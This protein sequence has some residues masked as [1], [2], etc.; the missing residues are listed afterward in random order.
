MQYVYD[1]I[2]G[3]LVFIYDLLFTLIY[4]SFA[5]AAVSIIILSIVI[6]LI[7]LPLY[8][9]ADKL[10]RDTQEK[11]RS[12]ESWIRHLKKNFKNDEQFMMLSAYYRINNYSPLS[13]I[14]EAVPLLLQIPFF[15]A[16]Y[17]YL[18]SLSLLERASWGPVSCLAEPDRLLVIGSF[19][20]NLL[21]VAM[22]LINLISGAVYSKGS[23]VKLKIQIAV[24]ALIFLV[25]LYNSPSGLVLYWT[26]NNVFSLA[27]NIIAGLSDRTRRYIRAGVALAVILTAETLSIMFRIQ[28]TVAEFLVIGS[29]IY[30]AF[31]LYDQKITAFLTKRFSMFM[32]EPV[33]SS[34]GQ[35]VLVLLSQ[36]ALAVLSGLCIPSSVVSSSVADFINESTGKLDPGLLTYP[37]MIWA[38]ILII[39]FSVIYLSMGNRGRRLL[40]VLSP[41]Y[42]ILSVLDY[43]VFSRS[44]GTLY[45]NLSFD[46]VIRFP[47][48]FWIIN[49]VT[50]I[51]VFLLCA[52][53]FGRKPVI[54]D[55][56]SVMILISLSAM[57]V[58][59]ISAVKNDRDRFEFEPAD[60]VSFDGILHLSRTGDN[61]IVFM[62]DRAI[63]GY[64]PYIFD[65]KP[66]LADSFTG[67]VYYP[68]TISFGT[69]TLHGSPGLFGGYEYTPAV[70]NQRADIPLVEKHNQALL[71]MPLLFEQNGYD[72]TVTDPPYAG[73][74]SNPDLSIYDEYPG[75]TA[76]K[77]RGVFTDEFLNEAIDYDSDAIQKHNFVMY[78][79][80]RTA[81]VFLRG[82][83][84]DDGKYIHNSIRTYYSREMLDNYTTLVNLIRM[85]RID[86]DPRGCFLLLQNETP[87]KPTALVPPD[88]EIDP[89]TDNSEINPDGTYDAE[90]RVLNGRTMLM[91]TPPQRNHYCINVATYEQVARWLDYLREEGVYD[92]TRIILV[93]DHG[94][95]LSQ[96]PDLISPDGLDVQSFNP[97]LM[98]KDFNSD[99]PFAVDSTFMTNADVPTL[100]MQGIIE[101]PVNPFTGN[102]VNNDRKYE[103]VLYVTDSHNWM[104]PGTDVCTFDVSDGN[105]W[106]ITDDLFNMNNWTRVPESEVH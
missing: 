99:G 66:E 93:A 86:D 65:E 41:G 104:P 105:W 17:N 33:L 95:Y 52:Y 61:V 80:Y 98:V 29:I 45:S 23:P 68:N 25:L 77:L 59:N 48:W 56:A 24:T 30:I 84:Y 70:M 72:V 2:I 103:G 62:L 78:S 63:S 58:M 67:F 82:F 37:A 57:S 89:L 28:T 1:L 7:V 92:N 39:W 54:L 102:P 20:V 44:F 85:T 47:V 106:S 19:T 51:L 75:I 11:Q 94:Y 38:G 3:S 96:F 13:F 101:D 27:K 100:A 50:V 40:A 49:T 53:V 55:F 43:F 4:R 90:N 60:I 9:K 42:L 21:P 71:L 31:T 46:G 87:H 35:F 74:L 10:Q 36:S 97:L 32:K 12:M 34:R 14:N 88:Y 76:Y 16:A 22:T 6:N 26:M 81:P 91:T 18:S 15:I 69:H 73:Y 8:N 79:A 64:I 5:D 83:I